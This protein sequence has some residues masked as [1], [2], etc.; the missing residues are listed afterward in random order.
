M[1]HD[2]FPI[3]FDIKKETMV[4]CQ[5]NYASGFPHFSFL[6]L[7][8]IEGDVVAIVLNPVSLW[9]RLKGATSNKSRN[10]IDVIPEVIDS[11][12]KNFEDKLLDE[13]DDSIDDIYTSCGHAEM[14]L[15]NDISHLQLVEDTCWDADTET[16]D[17]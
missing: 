11:V 16:D 12:G 6:L 7:W 14:V 17:C 8:Q 13:G 9:P 15:L 10:T 1:N 4:I 5:I 2:T 3:I